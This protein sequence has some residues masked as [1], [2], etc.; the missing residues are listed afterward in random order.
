MR[1]MKSIRLSRE[2]DR[3]ARGCIFGILLGRDLLFMGGLAVSGTPASDALT[4][5][6]KHPSGDRHHFRAP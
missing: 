4:L 3:N 2:S 5:G 6:P 1:T